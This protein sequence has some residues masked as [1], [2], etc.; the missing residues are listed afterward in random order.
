[1]FRGRPELKETKASSA[2]NV[3]S[4]QARYQSDVGI[5]CDTP[6]GSTKR[7]LYAYVV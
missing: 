6:D 5:H 4:G 3:T 1:M 7:A 2:R